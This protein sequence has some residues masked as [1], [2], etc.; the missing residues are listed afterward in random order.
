M[1]PVP[2]GFLFHVAETPSVGVISILVNCFSLAWKGNIPSGFETVC[3]GRHPCRLS[4][5]ALVFWQN[6]NPER[7]YV[8]IFTF[9]ISSHWI[10]LF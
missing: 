9:L 10:F 7:Q 2:M 3:C 4:S 1:G 6:M 8:E 5:A